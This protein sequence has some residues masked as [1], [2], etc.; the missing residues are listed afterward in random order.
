MD[1]PPRDTQPQDQKVPIVAA[2]DL[3]YGVHISES[4]K[5][6]SG[7][8]EI[9]SSAENA[10]I[11]EDVEPRNPEGAAAYPPPDYETAADI[12]VVSSSSCMIFAFE[13]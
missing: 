12:P 11:P 7:G 1:T 8:P 3:K 10:T 4:P 9:F 13:Q 5:S 2:T 6:T